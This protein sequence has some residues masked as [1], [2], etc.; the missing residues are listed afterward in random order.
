MIRL[1]ISILQSLTSRYSERPR[2]A[3]KWFVSQVDV[4]VS[5]LERSAKL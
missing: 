5:E 4:V 3:L 1:V 2:Y